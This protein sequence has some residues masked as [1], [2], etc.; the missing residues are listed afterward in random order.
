MHPSL[1]S[2]PTVLAK[3]PKDEDAVKAKVVA[4]IQQGET[5]SALTLIQGH[6][7]P[8]L[9]FALEKVSA[10]LGRSLVCLSGPV[11]CT[12]DC[13]KAKWLHAVPGL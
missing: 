2:F 5:A 7:N 12:A 11:F 8:G 13:S 9:P 10:N 6:A 4:L 3:S 1:T